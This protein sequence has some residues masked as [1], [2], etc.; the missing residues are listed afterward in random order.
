MIM[1]LLIAYTEYMTPQHALLMSRILHTLGENSWES[2]INLFQH[3]HNISFSDNVQGRVML[4]LNLTTDDGPV[5]VNAKQYHG[6]IRRRKSRAKA[7]LQ[8]KLTKNRKVW[9]SLA[10]T[11][12]K[13]YLQKNQN[14]FYFINHVSKWYSEVN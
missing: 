4:P 2:Q 5:F 14:Q 9:W 12:W 3:L 11:E 10:I 7:E 6:I 8:Q 13:F 1:R